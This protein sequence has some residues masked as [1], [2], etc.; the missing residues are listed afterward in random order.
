M[1]QITVLDSLSSDSFSSSVIY[2]MVKELENQACSYKIFVSEVPRESAGYGCGVFA[3]QDAVS[4]LQ[5]K[6]FLEHVDF[7]WEKTYGEHEA[8]IIVGL[9]PAFVIGMQ[10]MTN[11]QAYGQKMGAKVFEEA[12]SGRNK[13][14]N[15]YLGRNVIVVDGRKQNHYITKKTIQYQQ[16]IVSA[17]KELSTKEVKNLIH[18]SLLV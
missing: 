17:L 12:I 18:P 5:D 16:F 6:Q 15:E 14:L 3:L 7:G 9:P 2:D 10:S 13:T 11:V 8:T 1:L 4:F